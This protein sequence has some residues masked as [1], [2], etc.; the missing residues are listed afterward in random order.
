MSDY[1]ELRFILRECLQ[2]IPRLIARR[3][4][5]N[6][7]FRFWPILSQRASDRPP[8]CI[9]GVVTGYADRDEQTQIPRVVKLGTIW[10]DRFAGTGMGKGNQN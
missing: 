7:D 9:G 1:P 4:I 3:V 2:Y 5:D 8:D 10:N 6:D